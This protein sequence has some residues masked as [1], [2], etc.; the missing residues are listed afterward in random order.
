M[1]HRLH[2]A[3][4]PFHIYYRWYN[5]DHIV[6]DGDTLCHYS[7]NVPIPQSE[8]LKPLSGVTDH[9]WSLILAR[10]SNFCTLCYNMAQG[11]GIFPDR[12]FGEPPKFP[13]PECGD[14]ASRI[15]VIMGIASVDHEDGRYHQI[16]FSE[17][18]DW[19]RGETV[20]DQ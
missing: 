13:C 9:E 12:D 16:D 7:V 11:R 19:R 18:Q 17:Y 6:Q 10:G 4:S 15:T 3:R 1:D 20:Q 5:K 8:D 2:E 14:E